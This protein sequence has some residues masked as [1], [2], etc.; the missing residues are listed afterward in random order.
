MDDAHDILR[1]EIDMIIEDE[2]R[3]NNSSN[4]SSNELE[5]KEE[6]PF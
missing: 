4:E 5:Q 1:N 2:E 3:N 6:Y